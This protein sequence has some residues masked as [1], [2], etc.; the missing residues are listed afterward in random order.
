MHGKKYQKVLDESARGQGNYF[1]LFQ[2][3]QV[4]SFDTELTK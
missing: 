2:L 3:I 4:L 1:V